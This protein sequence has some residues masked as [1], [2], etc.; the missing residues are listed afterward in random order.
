MRTIAVL[1]ALMMLFGFVGCSTHEKTGDRT[2]PVLT[3]TSDPY[4]PTATGE[5]VGEWVLSQQGVNK[6]I[7]ILVNKDSKLPEGYEPILRS[8]GAKYAE[9]LHDDFQKMRQAAKSEGVILFIQDAHRTPEEQ[10]RIFAEMGGKL[11]APAGYSEHQTGLAIDFSHASSTEETAKSWEWLSKNA[12]KYGFI[13]R[14]PEGK[15][16]ITGYSYEPWHYRY[17][18]IDVATDIYSQ[19]IC[20]EEYLGEPTRAET[21][22]PPEQQ[23]ELTAPGGRALPPIG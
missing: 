12:Y 19:G 3:G 15:E 14:Y 17:V 21:G 4:L 1:F 23:G 18:G 2:E 11:A 20:L 9:V 8:E 5:L 6:D 10:E 22:E 13:L 7:L 16:H